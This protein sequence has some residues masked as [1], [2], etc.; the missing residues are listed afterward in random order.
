M[1][2]LDSNILIYSLQREYQYV[3]DYFQG[4]DFSRSIIS[5]VEVLGYHKLSNQEKN[6][7]EVLFSKIS[8]IAVIEEIIER[9]IHL[10]QEQRLTLGDALNSLGT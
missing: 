1:P 2:I 5:K 10:K 3:R 4:K 8:L 7:F 9:A 6:A